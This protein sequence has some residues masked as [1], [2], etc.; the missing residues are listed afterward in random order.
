M[1]TFGILFMFMFSAA[2]T[3]TKGFSNLK[4]SSLENHPEKLYI[5]PSNLYFSDEGIFLKIHADE[6]RQIGHIY[7]DAMGFYLAKAT[8]SQ[9]QITTIQNSK[10]QEEYSWICPSC[11][12]ENTTISGVCERCLWPLYEGD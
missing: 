10:E 8:S 2:F 4:T 5:D 12:Y 9:H 1:K 6:W 3:P 11:Y 7:H